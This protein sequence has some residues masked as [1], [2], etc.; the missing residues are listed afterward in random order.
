MDT[1]EETREINELDHDILITRTVTYPCGH[2]RTYGKISA[3][4]KHWM[5]HRTLC[6]E[7]MDRAQL[8]S[9]SRHLAAYGPSVAFDRFREFVFHHAAEY[10]P[11][12]FNEF[13]AEL[14]RN[15]R[16]TVT[17]DGG[18]TGP[19]GIPPRAFRIPG[20]GTATENRRTGDA[21]DARNPSRRQDAA[22]C[23]GTALDT[24]AHD[25]PPHERT[26][27]GRVRIPLTPQ[28]PENHRNEE[29]ET[30]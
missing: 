20:E 19:R 5:E 23:P 15:P 8:E 28:Q 10:G 2:T 4:Q 13:C 17:G 14:E 11:R 12:V 27:D 1:I 26:R 29:K 21:A 3:C 30:A 6:P 25:R 7:C 22:A 24:L 16:P 9:I 18:R